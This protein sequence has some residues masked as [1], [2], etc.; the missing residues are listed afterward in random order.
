MAAIDRTASRSVS[1]D[2]PKI[3]MDQQI[4]RRGGSVSD[5]INQLS[6]DHNQVKRLF[7]Q[8]S[9]LGAEPGMESALAITGLLKVHSTIEEELVYPVLRR[10]DD[11]LATAAVNDHAQATE[12]IASIEAMPSDL[13]LPIEQA[14][15]HHAKL[16]DAMNRL[17][18]AVL[19]H[20]AEEEDV[21]FPKLTA[22][23]TGEELENMGHAMYRRRQQLLAADGQ[24]VTDTLIGSPG[25]EGSPNI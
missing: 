8:W 22:G 21:I 15:D 25:W 20:V 11:G 24:G 1:G 23:C 14:G 13:G 6:G 4:G 5:P 9:H 17:H 12:I 7:N 3:V 2:A 10:L 18:Q 19:N 16:V